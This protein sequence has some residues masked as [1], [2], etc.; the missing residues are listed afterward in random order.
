MIESGMKDFEVYTSYSLYA[1]A[2]TPKAALE[3]MQKEVHDIVMAP[4]M[5]EILAEQAATPV[6][7]SVDEFNVEVKKDFRVLATPG[8]GSQPAS[9]VRQAT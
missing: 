8:Q 9:G 7:Q 4:D 6:A 1:P 3:R 5:K 2:K